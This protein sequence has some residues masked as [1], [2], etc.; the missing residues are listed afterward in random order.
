M[1]VCTYVCILPAQD[2]PL[3]VPAKAKFFGVIIFEP[4]N[5]SFIDQA[6]SVRIAGYWPCSFVHF[7][8][9]NFISVQ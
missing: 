5:K 4:Y 6:C 3:I 2:C 7:I 9:L 8:D 1:Y